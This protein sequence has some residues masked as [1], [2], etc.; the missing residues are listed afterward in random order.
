MAEKSAFE[1]KI[2]PNDLYHACAFLV[3]RFRVNDRGNTARNLTPIHPFVEA[4]KICSPGLSYKE[5][6]RLK[7]DILGFS[8]PNGA[9]MS[10]AI[11]G[12]A[13]SLGDVPQV[14]QG[15]AF[16][17]TPVGLAPPQMSLSGDRSGKRGAI[18][19]TESY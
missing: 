1:Q 16:V 12:R 4:V 3:T 14:L 10:K 17:Q 15:Y 11:T 7:K 13:S 19:S 5:R 18:W 9:V 2:Q 8:C 6:W